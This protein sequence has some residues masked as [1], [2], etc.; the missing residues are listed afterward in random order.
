MAVSMASSRLPARMF[1]RA[2]EL[3]SRESDSPRLAT[4]AMGS[5][6]GRTARAMLG[7]RRF[8]WLS[9][10][11]GRELRLSVRARGSRR[12]LFYTRSGTVATIVVTATRG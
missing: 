3:N 12:Q 7:E 2:L 10:P 1:Q 4:S 8:P 9:S 6:P 11:H 5:R